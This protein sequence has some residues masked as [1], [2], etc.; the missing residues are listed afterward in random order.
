M[1]KKKGM[2]TTA[3]NSAVIV[4]PT[5]EVAFKENIVD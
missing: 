5:K 2:W 1:K 3:L 4:D